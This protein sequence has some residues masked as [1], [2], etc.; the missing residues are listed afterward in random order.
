MNSST[1]SVGTDRRAIPQRSQ[2]WAVRTADALAAA[3]LTPNSIS[4][5]SVVVAT[6]AA[7]ALA[8]SG[9]TEGGVRVG[10]LLVAAV[11]M[12]LR[13]LLNMLDGMLAVEHDMRS[14][15]GELF[16]ELPDRIADVVVI[17]AAGFAT[18]GLMVYRGWDVGVGLAVVGAVLALLTAY[19]R[20]LGAS[21][22]VGNFF[23]GT[24]A[25]PIR[26][27]ILVVGCLLT[28]VEMALGWPTGIVFAVALAIVALGSLETVIT[29]LRHITA[30]LK[31]KP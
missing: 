12:P 13:L 29:R 9:F 8:A 3:K 10:F 22:G 27:W 2:R 18:A 16:N 24:M 15:T 4:V 25:K 28:L 11:G 14:P 7:V 17:T 23:N 26:M 20:T 21:C 5:L 6:V 31:A 30:A 19:V 1:N